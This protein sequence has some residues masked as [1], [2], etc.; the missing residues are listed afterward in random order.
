MI[1]AGLTLFT[2]RGGGDVQVEIW[3]VFTPFTNYTLLHR[4]LVG[5]VEVGI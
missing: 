3:M 4:E 5:A 2:L 1:F